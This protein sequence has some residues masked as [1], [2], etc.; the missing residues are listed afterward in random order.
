MLNGSTMKSSHDAEVQ[1][2]GLE[3][4]LLVL[5]QDGKDNTT[6]KSGGQPSEMHS[7]LLYLKNSD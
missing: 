7:T 4:R 5:P 6:L 2:S 3:G 1:S